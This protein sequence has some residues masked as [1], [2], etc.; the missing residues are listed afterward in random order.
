M[1]VRSFALATALSSI[2]LAPLAAS[3]APNPYPYGG[4]NPNGYANVGRI[5]GT[6][7]SVNGGSARL[8]NGRTIFLR[9]T[10]SIRPSGQSLAAGQHVTIVGT[11]AGDG[12]INAQSLTIDGYS[13]AGYAPN[14]YQR[15]YQSDGY[16]NA[17]NH[18]YRRNHDERRENDDR[19]SHDSND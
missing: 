19:R 15:G 2:A 10:T 12:N 9:D 4:Y 17:R 18:R 13:N 5:S 14:G 3:A 8:Q 16:N 7:V 6:I 1:N 11:D